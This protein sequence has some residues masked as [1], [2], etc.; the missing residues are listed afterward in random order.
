MTERTNKILKHLKTAPK[1]VSKPSGFV[2]PNHSGDHSRGKVRVTAVGDTDIANKKYVDDNAGGGAGDVVGPASST[3]NAVARF[4]STTGKL[5]QD[6]STLIDDSENVTGVNNITSAAG[7][8]SM[9]ADTDTTN[10]F[11][12]FATHSTNSDWAML[13][14]YDD[15][16]SGSTYGI[17]LRTGG[18]TIIN[19]SSSKTIKFTLNGSTVWNFTTASH[20]E[21]IS[22]NSKN[23]GS[24]A[25]R[26][27]SLYAG[28]II[29][30]GVTAG[31][32]AGT[33]QSQ[34]QGA[35]TTE[36]NEVA[37][38][39]NANDVVTLATAVAGAQMIIMNN[40]ANTLQ[41]FPASGDNLGAGV[42]TST[43]LAA[44]SNVRYVAYDATNWENV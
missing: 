28:T 35:L 11:G 17:A 22:N 26:I 5:L 27:M 9:A 24:A 8:M 13:S 38:V 34:G 21:P 41:I 39:A 20:L 4:D 1:I 43:T 29:H 14:H 33:T 25:V 15:R 19:S 6:S 40:G 12:R 31:I 36:V 37:T 23:I 3:D 30:R 2:L 18:E 42:N 7:V 16:A 10:I 32:T 44:G